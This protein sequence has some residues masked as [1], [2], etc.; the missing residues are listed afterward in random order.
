MKKQVGLLCIFLIMIFVVP[1]CNKT[2]K[3]MSAGDVQELLQK[4]N[5][6][7]YGIKIQAKD[8][9]ISARPA[10]LEDDC[11]GFVI[12]LKE[13]EFTFDSSAAAGLFPNL[14]KTVIPIQMKEM[15]L[16]YDYAKK[17]LGF[18]SSSEMVMDLNLLDLVKMEKPEAKEGDGAV[19]AVKA[20]MKISIDKVEMKNYKITALLNSNEKTVKDFLI[21]LW[22]D[23]PRAH[24]VAANMDMK[25]SLDMGPNDKIDFSLTSERI[26]GH[27]T[28][29]PDFFI[30][31]FTD[32][33]TV[34]KADR[35]MAGGMPMFH[36]YGKFLN[37]NFFVS[38]QGKEVAV[39]NLWQLD[40]AN[41]L[42][43]DEKGKFYQY[44]FFYNVKQ[45]RSSIPAFEGLEQLATNFKELNLNFTIEHLTPEVVSDYMNLTSINFSDKYKTEEERKQAMMLKGMEFAP[46]IL[47]S[48]PIFNIT[49][50]PFRN[51]FGEVNVDS[52][53]Q[54][55]NAGWPQGK[56]TVRVK[57]MDKMA[58]KI[59]E[60]D[61]ITDPIKKKLIF[62]LNEYFLPDPK[63][64]GVLTLE[65]QPGQPGQLI[66]NGKPLKKKF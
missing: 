50:L 25:V 60:D 34:E 13:P 41:F 16:T 11:E 38:V 19:D 52:S 22:Q 56:A 28:M 53:F 44:G 61:F 5:S 66:L 37:S 33:L 59:Q 14:K 31:W 62:F 24:S 45:L 1:G 57:E 55:I 63:N 20:T 47:A 39:G 54:F 64:T 23:N 26:E 2:P 36:A 43:P 48:Q 12:T 10:D 65:V 46:K 7:P 9:N 8:E 35:L 49:I 6:N 58:L 15:V 29:R 27:Q 3:K 4:M 42:K 30:A 21:Q 32:K 17:Q 51:H 18:L 40:F